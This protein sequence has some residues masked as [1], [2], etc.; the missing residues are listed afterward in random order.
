MAVNWEC[1]YC[2]RT[3]SVP[4]GGGY[5]PEPSGSAPKPPQGGS[6]TMDAVEREWSEGRERAMP[7]PLPLVT[8]EETKPDRAARAPRLFR[9]AAPLTPGMNQGKSL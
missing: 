5:Q 2:K 6:G 1:P 7:D 3:S 4:F 9:A 8:L